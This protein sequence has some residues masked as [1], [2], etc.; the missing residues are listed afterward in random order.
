MSRAETLA[1]LNAKSVTID[2]MPPGGGTEITDGLIAAA[3]KNLPKIVQA[4]ARVR[5]AGQGTSLGELM[6]RHRDKINDLAILNGWQGTPHSF[7]LFADMAMYDA[8]SDNHC[9]RCKGA[10]AHN[11]RKVCVTCEGT[12]RGT[13]VTIK[14][15]AEAIGV[16][17]YMW[18][19][20][21]ESRLSVSAS[22]F[23]YYD[24]QI[25]KE[26]NIQLFGA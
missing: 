25:A 4:Y 7:I 22:D 10:G 9:R 5:Y 23:A 15:R 19:I 14:E 1:R 12:G 24:D 21:W 20:H 11:N 17:P 26:L 16:T 2:G 6:T 18:K 3:I 8:I 13:A